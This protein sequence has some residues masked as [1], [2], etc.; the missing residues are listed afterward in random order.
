MSK[1]RTKT[2]AESGE[3]LTE[4][5]KQIYLAEWFHNT[6]KQ[7]IVVASNDKSLAKTLCKEI[8]SEFGANDEI[9]A[10]LKREITIERQGKKPGR[11]AKRTED[12][13][14]ILL[15]EYAA[16]WSKNPRDVALAELAGKYLV[17][18]EKIDQH[19]SK[20]RK[21]VPKSRLPEWAQYVLNEQS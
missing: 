20:A 18:G 15:I 14:Q 10:L 21:S 2:I 13:Y 19:L 3:P 4:E 1:S 11:Q 9:G 6:L 5:E 16:L 17:A 12:T 7:L 8:V